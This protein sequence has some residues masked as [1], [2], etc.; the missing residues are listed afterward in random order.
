IQNRDGRLLVED[1]AR[2]ADSHTRLIL[3]SSVQWNN[4]YRADLAAFSQLCR[5]RRITL[6][7]DAIQQLGAVS[8]DVQRTRV[9]FL[10]CGGH[11]WLN[12]PV[13]RGFLYV[14]PDRLGDTEPPAW[15]Y[16]NVEQPPE[17]WAEYF[18]TPTNPAV[19]DY[20]FTTAARRFELGGTA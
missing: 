14:H 17:G 18:A 20:S 2:A 7:V 12:V 4:G 9:D 15:G 16:L 19:R 5:E 3:L 10:V 8:L 6:V 13:G 11:K 1:Y